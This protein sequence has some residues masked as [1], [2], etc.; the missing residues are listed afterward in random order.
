MLRHITDA[1]VSRCTRHGLHHLTPQCP[2]C[3][4]AEAAQRHADAI[5]RRSKQVDNGPT[6]RGSSSCAPAMDVAAVGPASLL[7]E[8]DRDLAQAVRHADAVNAIVD[9]FFRI[10]QAATDLGRAFAVSDIEV[11]R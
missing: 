10:H 9:G 3:A 5:V 11:G 4:R 6:A 7:A 8:A 2:V 1:V